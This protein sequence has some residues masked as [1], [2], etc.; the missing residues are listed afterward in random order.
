MQLIDLSFLVTL[1]APGAR[2]QGPAWGSGPIIHYSRVWFSVF[3]QDHNSYGRGQMEH[4][5]CVFL[6]TLRFDS[7]K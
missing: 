5:L 2:V 7:M 4:K 6:Q 1:P 3:L